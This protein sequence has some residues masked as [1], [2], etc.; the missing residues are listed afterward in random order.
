MRSRLLVLLALLVGGVLVT[1][2]CGDSKPPASNPDKGV[3]WPEAGGGT[4]APLDLPPPTPDKPFVWPDIKPPPDTTP[5]PKTEGYVPGPFGCQAD[6]DCFGQK[7]CPTP[8]GV[9]LCAPTCDL[10]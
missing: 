6:S 5:W 1:T 9:K 3:Q 2:S 4:D 7:C 10:K 8:W